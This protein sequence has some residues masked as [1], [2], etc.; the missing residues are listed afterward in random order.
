[1]SDQ[2]KQR[3]WK[4]LREHYESEEYYREACAGAFLEAESIIHR[5]GGAVT[6]AALRG[7]HAPG[8]FVQLGVLFNWSSFV[9][10]VNQR[11]GSEAL[12][13]TG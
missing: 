6:T 8:E 13:G 4:V 10:T 9:P 1:M 7:E 2:P 5:L 11:N 12:V 3:Q